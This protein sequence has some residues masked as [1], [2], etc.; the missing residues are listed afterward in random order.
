M[1]GTVVTTQQVQ[2][3]RH[4]AGRAE[5]TSGLAE[6]DSVQVPRGIVVTRPP[7]PAFGPG[8]AASTA[9]SPSPTASR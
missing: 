9:G 7:A 8:A 1:R 4:F 3:G 6:G 2:V 5:I